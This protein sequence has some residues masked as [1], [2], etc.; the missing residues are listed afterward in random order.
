M[1]SEP[2]IEFYCAICGQSLTADPEFGGGV[3]TCPA[4]D[5]NVPVPGRFT[6]N[7]AE[8]KLRPAFS[9]EIVSVDL[10]FL[11]PDCDNKLVVDARCSGEPY[12]CPLCT[13]AGEVPEWAHVKARGPDHGEPVVVHALTLSPEEIDFLSGTSAKA[14]SPK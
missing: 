4:C 2:L 14:G 8:L 12:V 11:C 6:R 9:P 7:G 10:T 1:H 13:T 3:I 5:R